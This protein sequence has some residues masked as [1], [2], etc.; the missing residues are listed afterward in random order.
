MTPRAGAI[1]E[2]EICTS[3]PSPVTSCATQEMFR[4]S[5]YLALRAVCCIIDD[6]VVCLDGNLPT[7]YLKQVAQEIAIGVEGVRQ[8]VNRIEVVGSTGRS[9]SLSPPLTARA[10][11]SPTAPTHF[12][13]A[14]LPEHTQA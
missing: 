14:F 9:H 11:S 10:Y 8:V 3:S 1:A 6:G 2:Q 7:H 4:A 12:G 5:N 13:R